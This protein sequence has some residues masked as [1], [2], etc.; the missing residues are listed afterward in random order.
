MQNDMFS[1]GNVCASVTNSRWL[2][3]G[4]SASI[5]RSGTKSMIVENGTK[6]EFKRCLLKA[7]EHQRY[8]CGHVEVAEYIDHPDGG[9]IGTLAMYCPRCIDHN[10]YNVCV[11]MYPVQPVN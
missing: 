8:P 9:W 1:A 11:R 4:A 10:R 5:V 6:K 7:V 2:P 3:T